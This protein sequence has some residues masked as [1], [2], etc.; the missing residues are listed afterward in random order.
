MAKIIIKTDGR[1]RLADA[2]PG[3][4]LSDV[5]LAAGFFLERPCAGRGTCGKCKVK[6]KGSFRKPSPVEKKS[7]STSELKAGVRLACQAR[8]KG[9]AQIAISSRTVVTDKI[10]SGDGKG[11][12][13]LRGPFGIAIDLGTTTVAAFLSTLEDSRVHRGFAV[14]NRQGTFGAEVISRMESAENGKAPELKDLAR[15]SI[16]QAASGLGLKPVQ[17]SQIER[18]VVVGNSAMHHLFLGLPVSTLTRLPFQPVERKARKERARFFG[19]EIELWVPPLIAGFV[20]SD[21]LA[22]LVY[23]GFATRGKPM[24][25]VDLGTNGEVMV[26]DG[27]EIAVASTAAGPAFEGV[28]IECGMRATRGAISGAARGKKG[29][30][31]LEV[32]GGGQPSGIAGSGLLSLV[33]LLRR[34]GGINPSGRLGETVRL[35]DRVFLSQSDVREVQKAKA[36]VRAA[37]DI[38]LK[39]LGLQPEDLSELVLTGSFGARILVDDALGLGMIPPVKKNRVKVFANAAGMGAGM[40]LSG[41]AFDFAV[42]L[43]ERVRHVELYADQEFMD[44]FVSNMIF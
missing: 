38:L 9:S 30:F 18:A 8:V 44:K 43:A 11:V 42:E 7:L 17:L 32:I 27:R 12:E 19:R 1:E 13:K 10:F 31:E 4:L 33:N 39:H 3:E 21:T 36:A 40:L 5:I 35:T 14:L 41:E 26:S 15:S 25:A 23:L 34:E 20:G 16:E 6:T 2:R 28:N 29:G 22:C 24:A 37:F